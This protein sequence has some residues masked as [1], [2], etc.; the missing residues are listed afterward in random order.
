MNQAIKHIFDD[1]TLFGS[2]V[3][4]GFLVILFF[5]LGEQNLSLKLLISLILV[6]VITLPIRYFYFK[7]RPKKI[8]YSNLLERLDAS[9]FPSMHSMRASI[10]LI[11]IPLNYSSWLL[12]IFFGILAIIIWFSRYVVRK[13]YPIDI[14]VGAILG[15]IIA[16]L[17]IF[18]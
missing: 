8:H 5:L 9:S 13:H 4:Q 1:L 16:G 14:F 18:F 10:L 2:V 12:F 17:L 11:L 7:D 3:F 15:F 6:Y